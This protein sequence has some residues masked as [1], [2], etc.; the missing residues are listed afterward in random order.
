MPKIIHSYNRCMDGVDWCNQFFQ[1]IAFA[2]VAKID[3]C[4]VNSWIIFKLVKKNS[5]S[6]LKFHREVIQQVLKQCGAPRIKTGPNIPYNPNATTVIR[7]DK[8][9]HW[10]VAMSSRY[11]RCRQCG[12]RCSI[13]CEKCDAPLYVKCFKKYYE[14]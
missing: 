8:V 5:I 3:A 11:S 1:I 12:G 7:F 13:K 14:N 9:N 4:I 2:Y 6:I 10:P